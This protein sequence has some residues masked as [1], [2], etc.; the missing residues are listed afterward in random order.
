MM[1][2]PPPHGPVWLLLL[3]ALAA[4]AVYDLRVRRIPNALLAAIAVAGLAHALVV[5]GPRL[6]LAAA[7][8]AV[9]GAALLAWPFERGLLGGGDVKL[10]ASLGVW[11]GVIGVVR[12]LLVG[13]VAGG[14]LALVSLARL[15]R[16]DRADVRRGLVSFARSGRL[17][18]PSPARLCAARGVP[19]A[20][21][22]AA[23]GA[24][25]LCV[26]GAR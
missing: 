3:A 2:V 15:T 14:L 18:V 21:A 17:A 7:L 24:W 23:G 11:V 19:Y 6:G 26:G 20:V 25:A 5:G 13:A 12:V 8:G 9:A 16:A 4:V 1:N 10:L 22:L